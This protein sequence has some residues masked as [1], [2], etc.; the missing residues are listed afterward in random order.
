MSHE[1]D[2][3]YLAFGYDGKAANTAINDLRQAQTGRGYSYHDNYTD[4]CHVQFVEHGSNNDFDA[5]T[6]KRARSWGLMVSGR[7]CMQHVVEMAQY[8]ES[9]LTLPYGREQLAET[10]IKANRQRLKEAKPLS[11]LFRFLE[12][13]QIE[14]KLHLFDDA[15]AS[16][17][18]W[19]VM[20]QEKGWTF[21]PQYAKAGLR[22]VLDSQ[23]ELECLLHTLPE[24]SS[25]TCYTLASID[26][27][28]ALDACHDLGQ[29][30]LVG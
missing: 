12:G 4:P 23:L 15:K 14:L 11:E 8:V 19:W 2:Y 28:S 22:F 6:N 5:F 29:L 1:I 13:R 26:F 24:I 27:G 25:G 9:G 10:Y 18:P 7:G 20:A 3:R 30:R 16:R 17:D 21:Q